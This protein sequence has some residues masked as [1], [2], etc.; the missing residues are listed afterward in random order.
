M[1]VS[2]SWFYS[3]CKG[4]A[5]CLMLL[6]SKRWL[7]TPLLLPCSTELGKGTCSQECFTHQACPWLLATWVRGTSVH[8][9][10]V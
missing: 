6:I 4:N 3:C 9:K 7:Q 1:T 5:S 10:Q 2:Y 8:A